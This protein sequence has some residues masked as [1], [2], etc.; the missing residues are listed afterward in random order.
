MTMDNEDMTFLRRVYEKYFPYRAQWRTIGYGLGIS[1]RDLDVIDEDNRGKCDRCFM[2]VLAKWLDSDDKREENELDKVIEEIEGKKPPQANHEI[3]PKSDVPWYYFA[4]AVAIIGVTASVVYSVDQTA[5]SPIATAAQILKGEYIHPVNEF[6]LLDYAGD[7]PFLNISMR[8]EGSLV[9][10]RQLF[11]KIDEEY[12]RYI[13]D[14]KLQ[15]ANDKGPRVLITGHP[16][17]GKTT[18]LRHLAKEWAEG[19]A[20]RSCQILFLIHLDRLSKDRK[21]QSLSDLLEL[22]PHNDLNS[23]QQVFEKIQIKN[24]TGVCFL[25]DSYDGWFWTKDYVD[26]L[27]FGGSLPSSLCVLTSRPLYSKEKEGKIYNVEIVGFDASHLES[28]LRNLSNDHNTV[29]SILNLWERDENTKDL[30]ELPL[31]MVM[32]IYIAKHGGNLL[33]QT[34]TQVYIAFMNVTIQHFADHHPDWNTVSLKH[35]I[36]RNDPNDELCVAF[37]HLAQVAFEILFDRADK[38]PEYPKIV[39]NIN[40]LGFVNVRKLKTTSDQVKYTFFHPTFIEYYAAIHLLKLSDEQRFYLYVKEQHYVNRKTSGRIPNFWLFLYGLLGEHYGDASTFVPN[41]LRLFNLYY[42]D[43][44][45]SYPPMEL[46]QP[47]C[48]YKVLTYIREIGWT[49]KDLDS[50]LESSG[51]LV[52]HSICAEYLSDHDFVGL[53]YLLHHA[54]KITKVRLG[55]PHFNIILLT[56]K[57]KFNIDK[58][59]FIPLEECAGSSRDFDD[60]VKLSQALPNIR[61]FHMDILSPLSTNRTEQLTAAIFDCLMAGVNLR[62]MHLGLERLESNNLQVTLASIYKCTHNLQVLSLN[63]KL[64][65][66]D[67]P[68]VVS[69]LNTLSS[70]IKVKLKID[71]A[72]NGP[73]PETAAGPLDGLKHPNRIEALALVVNNASLQ[74]IVTIDKLT[75]LKEFSFSFSFGKSFRNFTISAVTEL[76][77]FLPLTLFELKLNN[78]YINDQDVSVLAGSLRSMRSLTALGLSLNNITGIGLRSLAD[79]LKSHKNFTKLDLSW[80]PVGVDGVTGIELLANLSNLRELKLSNCSI[81]ER[82][83]EVLVDALESNSNF[84]YLNLSHN[85]FIGNMDGL[86]QLA[87]LTSVRYLDISGWSLH[88]DSVRHSREEEMDVELKY[89]QGKIH[90]Q[91]LNYILKHLTQLQCLNL[92]NTHKERLIHWSEE[93]ASTISKLPNLHLLNAPCLF[94]DN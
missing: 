94:V 92:C 4:I 36:M 72:K 23:I 31:H 33:V 35:C 29:T 39:R 77:K 84:R 78:N 50:L 58:D 51:L 6:K 93:L 56:G 30:C 2:E 47:G 44:G 18:L 45:E 8:S 28:Y 5:V 73:C 62:T 11:S 69:K 12:R 75:G 26:W 25:L 13:Q 17:A 60:I 27:F 68:S 24:G 41:L 79:A 66:E 54:N 57:T 89:E 15:H 88:Y 40:K 91:T 64:Y 32:L 63:I 49:G 90:G 1:K 85:P 16:G 34:K 9:D 80:N 65:C 14:T 53:T 10:S 86:K 70:E 52:N 55:P 87:R 20:L 3:T 83:M 43:K 81:G 48:F 46:R 37:H 7:M 38:F 21:P 59:F 76:A 42:K 61:H 22:T 74:E 82:E 71:V 19:R 67:L